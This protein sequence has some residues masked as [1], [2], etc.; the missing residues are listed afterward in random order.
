MDAGDG[1]CRTARGA[2]RSTY[3]REDGTRA[4]SHLAGRRDCVLTS[5]CV[6]NMVTGIH[7]RS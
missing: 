2:A 5:D 7:L 3:S 1:G 6:V 4:R